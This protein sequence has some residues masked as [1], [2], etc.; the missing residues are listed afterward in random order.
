[1][2]SHHFVKEGQEPALLI[3]DPVPFSVAESLLEWAPLVI[4]TSNALDE[5]LSWNIKIDVV[6]AGPETVEVLNQKLASQAPVKI[7]TGDPEQVYKTA[8]FFL[9]A[10]KQTAVS[11]LVE[12]PELWMKK[13]TDFIDKL[14]ITIR[15][16]SIRW[17]GISSGSFKKWL[18]AGS[19]LKF[20]G[21]DLTPVHPDSPSIGK[22]GV[23]IADGLI[24]FR[25][26][27]PFWVGEPD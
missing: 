12:Q 9:V 16:P 14:A 17:S 19:R 1:M 22:E 26:S 11:V 10:N 6:I 15:S 24:D 25:H 27:T 2:S 5:V 3:A 8:V 13:M 4:V 23:I 7:I 21:L 18:P 20:Y